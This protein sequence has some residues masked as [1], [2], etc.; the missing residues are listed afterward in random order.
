MV[1]ITPPFPRHPEFALT[2]PALGA[3]G[4]QAGLSCPKAHSLPGQPP[5]FLSWGN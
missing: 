4:K 3:P 5:A 2:K 1:L